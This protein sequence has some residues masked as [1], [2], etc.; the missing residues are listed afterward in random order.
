MVRSLAQDAFAGCKNLRRV[1]LHL[2]PSAIPVSAAVLEAMPEG[3]AVY[4]PKSMYGE[5]AT[6][7]FWS[8]MMRFV[9]TME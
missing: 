6:D 8:N 3:C 1:E 2:A 5:F 4:I 7:Y 9:K